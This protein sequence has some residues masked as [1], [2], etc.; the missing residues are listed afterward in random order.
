MHPLREIIN[1][2]GKIA[3]G[4]DWPVTIGGYEYGLNP[5]TNI[6]HAMTRRT[7]TSLVPVWGTT[8]EPMP[9]V[10]QV[11]TLEEAIRGYTLW[12]AE[13][14]GKADMIGSIEVGKKADIIVLDQDLF[15]LDDIRKTVDTKVLLTMFDGQVVHDREFG[16]GD[17]SLVDPEILDG[18]DG[19]PV[20]G[21]TTMP[22]A[23]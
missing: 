10:D 13:R 22:F 20:H 21:V 6:Y 7:A 4:S 11:I 16:V 12:G 15:S 3:L 14:M 2:G 1:L 23:H 8:D 18:L 19:A 17:S 9:P 5:F